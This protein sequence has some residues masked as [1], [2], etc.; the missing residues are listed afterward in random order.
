M[1]KAFVLHN[2]DNQLKA[3]IQQ[4]D[5]ID[6]PKGNVEVAIDYS[7][8][9]YKDAL[10]ITG[11]GQIIRSFPMVPGID[12]IG[13]VTSSS[14]SRY[15]QGNQVVLT[16]HGVGEKHWGGMAEK[17]KVNADWL[18]PLVDGLDSQ[19][20]MQIGTA[21]LTAMLSV[22]AIEEAGMTPEQGEVLVTGASGGV[23]S[24]VISLLAALGY[25]VVAVTAR[26]DNKASLESLGARRVIS[27]DELL[28]AIKPLD[29]QQW[30]AVIDC[31]GSHILAKAISQTQYGGV[32][33]A[34]GLAAGHDLDTTVLPFILRGVKLIGI[35]SVY[36]PYQRRLTAWQRLAQ[37]LPKEFFADACQQISLEQVTDCSKKML[38]GQVK[39]RLVIKI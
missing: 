15:Q 8:L 36:C 12:F 23:G 14:D 28:T 4:L 11:K 37:L 29:S 24:V 30:A 2:E 22:M 6:L 21:G 10:A 33:T 39:G 26:M 18:V 27:R 25:S 38:Q 7:S 19:Q 34:C 31:V 1:F 35:D 32:V 13:T 5:E 3:G 17:A 16:G 20:A 9:N